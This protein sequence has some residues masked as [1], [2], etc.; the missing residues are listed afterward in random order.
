[1]K[2]HERTHTGEE[3]YACGV[4]GQRFSRSGYMKTHER[5]HTGGKP[6]TGGL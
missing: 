5:T 3:P 1:M 4:C 6:Y 2:A